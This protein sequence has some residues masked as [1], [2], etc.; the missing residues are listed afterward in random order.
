[1]DRSPIARL[2]SFDGPVEVIAGGSEHA[3]CHVDQIV[4]LF[5]SDF[6][7]PT[8]DEGFT[9]VFNVD[10]FRRKLLDEYVTL[11]GFRMATASIRERL[12]GFVYGSNLLSGA[13][14][15]KTIREPLPD[16]FTDEDGKRTVAL[17]D[18]CVKRELRG[19]HIASRLHQ[20]FLGGHNEG[21]HAQ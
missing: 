5:E 19:K 3:R 11:S 18:I 10:R 1:M 4:S 17:L 2:R 7:D 20:S 12:V 14:W 15:W 9:T 6:F 13:A 16:G 8:V 21:G